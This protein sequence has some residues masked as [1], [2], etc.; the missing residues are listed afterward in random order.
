MF[1]FSLS[2]KK[3]INAYINEYNENPESIYL[4]DV[5]ADDEY[6]EKHIP[7]SIHLPLSDL[8][9][10]EYELED[11]NKTVY[12]YCR[13]GQRA[14]RAVTMLKVMGFENA[15][16]IGGIENYKGKTE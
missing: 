9:E 3:D 16:N 1:K 13:S 2:G 7:G 5:R 6:L 10:A 14:G 8:A 15:V 12:V 11:K 4:L